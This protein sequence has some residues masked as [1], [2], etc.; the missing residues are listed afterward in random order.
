MLFLGII[1]WK[2]ASRFRWG[3]LFLGGGVH[4]MG[5]DIGFDGGA[6][7]VFQFRKND[8]ACE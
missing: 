8:I 6:V 2:G 3:A 4:P 1:S 5:K 7:S